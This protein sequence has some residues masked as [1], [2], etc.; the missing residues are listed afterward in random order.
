MMKNNKDKYFVYVMLH[1]YMY[2]LE[3]RRLFCPFA[4]RENGDA[5]YFIRQRDDKYYVISSVI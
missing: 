2:I 1:A 4:N 5:R 3:Y